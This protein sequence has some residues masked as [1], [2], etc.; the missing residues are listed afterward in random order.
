MSTDLWQQADQAIRRRHIPIQMMVEVTRRCNLH[1]L[2]CYNLKDQS[3]LSFEEVSLI[4]AQ[5]RQAGCL[6][7]TLTGGEMF[8]R[9]DA[10]AVI[11]TFRQKGFDVK[12]ITNATLI[13]DEQAGQL[14]DLCLSEIGVSILGACAATHDRITGVAGSFEK[15]TRMIRRLKALDVPVHLKCT[16]MQDN[17]DEEAALKS[18]AQELGV[19]YLMDPIVSPQD[20]GSQA[21]LKHRLT[22]PQ[23]ETFYSQQFATLE[24]VP[25]ST[26]G[27]PCEAGTTFGAISAR[28][29]VYPCIQMPI[30]VGNIFKQDFVSIWQGARFLAKIRQAESGHFSTCHTCHDAKFCTRCPGLAYLEDGDAFGPST[31]AC[32][33]AKISRNSQEC[34]FTR[35]VNP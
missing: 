19:I 34:R 33:I 2:H 31:V 35:Q 29:D 32:Q 10:I 12:L 27:L 14:R 22:A 30:P 17:L 11:R 13:A 9:P 8:T 1:C 21:A 15:S 16:L 4:A 23:M 25:A 5:L 24:P 26:D 20:N 3:V 28:G 7:V 6:F 18:L